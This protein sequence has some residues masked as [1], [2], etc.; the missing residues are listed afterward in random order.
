MT[1]E[2]IPSS[3]ETGKEA[4][5]SRRSFITG[6]VTVAAVAGAVAPAE[7]Q[8]REVRHTNPSGLST[9][10]AYAQLVEV[11]G[12]Q[13][14]ICVA[15]QTGTD[16]SGKLAEGFRA[17]AV[18]A[19]E[20]IKAALASVGGGFEHVVKLNTYLTDIDASLAA[21]GEVRA[22]YF[23]NKAALPASTLVQ[24]SRLVQRNAMIEV[25]VMAM[26]PPKA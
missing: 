17:Q 14:I 26:L 8:T 12:P 13:R 20:N 25:E 4:V 16:A 15:G 18:Q 5:A 2:R 9:P 7:A 23:S 1:D 6:A 19:M 21:Y 24:V 11:N 10:A 3:S 22:T